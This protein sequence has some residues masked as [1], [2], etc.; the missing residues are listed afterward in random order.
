[1]LAYYCATVQS[2]IVTSE[3]YRIFVLVRDKVLMQCLFF[4]DF[5]VNV[6]MAFGLMTAFEAKTGCPLHNLWVKLVK[7]LL[8]VTF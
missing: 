1:M 4:R 2:A 8:L 6:L 5:I 3:C 7:I